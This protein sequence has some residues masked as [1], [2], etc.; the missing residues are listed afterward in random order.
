MRLSKAAL[1]GAAIATVLGTAACDASAPAQKVVSG[2]RDD[3]KY[4]AAV[5]EK[6]HKE[7]ASSTKCTRRVA[8]K[9]KA[10]KTTK[11]W[12]KVIDRRAKPA[13]YCVELDNVNGS[14]KDDDV[15]YTTSSSVYWSAVA[16]HEGDRMKFKPIH[17]GCW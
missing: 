7:L 11:T 5:R 8:G 14:S 1:C 10:T 3:V 13:L 15:W 2:D 16:K 9:C 12:K 17:G 6:S 4:K